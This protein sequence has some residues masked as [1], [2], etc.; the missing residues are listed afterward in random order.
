MINK[1]FVVSAGKIMH[2]LICGVNKQNHEKNNSRAQGGGKR[3]S[4]II[5]QRTA[6]NEHQ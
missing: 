1:N 3:E 4:E 5:A 6:E 2:K